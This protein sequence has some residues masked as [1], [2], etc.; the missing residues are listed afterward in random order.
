MRFEVG[1]GDYF[2]LFSLMVL[3]EVTRSFYDFFAVGVDTIEHF[4]GDILRFNKQF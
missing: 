1:G 4:F 3:V 2:V